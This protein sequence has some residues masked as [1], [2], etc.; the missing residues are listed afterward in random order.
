MALNYL[1]IKSD[2]KTILEQILISGD[3]EPLE[4]KNKSLCRVPVDIRAALDQAFRDFGLDLLERECDL[5][6][7][8]DYVKLSIGICRKEMAT[9]TIPVMLLADIFDT[10]T[11][12]V[13]EDMFTFVEDEVNVWKEDL[14]FTSCKNNLLRMCNDL[15]RRLSRSSATVFC[16]RIL[17]FL[18]KF[19]PFSERSGLNIVSEFNLENLTEY[20][21][22]ASEDS[23]T[24]IEVMGSKKNIVIDY[25]LYCK[26]WS[27]QDFFRNPN[28]CYTKVQWKLFCSHAT[29]IL[30]TFEG[31]KLDYVS[32][33][34]DDEDNEDTPYF[35]KYLT[36]QKLLDLQI[37]DVNFRRSVLL[38][39][40]ILFQYL[41]SNVKFKSENYEL[42]SDQKEWV[43]N[44]TEKVYALLRETPP[45]GD[46]F[47]I[48][49]KNILQREENWNVWKNDG[50]P[51]FKTSISH[52][53]ET[54][55]KC[56]KTISE[57]P[58]VGDLLK[59]AHASG[60]YYLGSTELTKLWNLSPDN[61]EACKAKDR[62]FLP[63]LD[64]Y[65][66]EAIAQLEGP[67]K[68]EDML[69]KD[70]NFGW[71]A[72]RL[73]ARRSP[74]FFAYNNNPINQLPDYLEMM[75]KKIAADRP[76]RMPE[77]SDQNV[78][79]FEESL[80]K[81]TNE[82]MKQDV[83]DFTDDHNAHS[84]PVRITPE[85]LYTISDAVASNW[86]IL[87]T[88]LGFKSDEIKYFEDNN[89][90]EVERA[91]NILQLW[92]E[93]EDDP[94]FENLAYILEGLDMVNAAEV[95]KS[96]IKSVE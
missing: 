26:F 53:D 25:S 18:A 69:L 55:D 44:V 79:E 11:L 81:E 88:K 89:S 41:T 31:L 3:I 67:A 49:I 48:I 6:I 46:K 52:V 7:L 91:Q 73:I 71:R 23:A 13:C 61:L 80:F 92:F 27:L 77:C 96:A 50:C 57:R 58:L 14:F 16:G 15:L 20:G 84:E 32:K 78:V 8:K 5:H 34:V 74:H 59:E 36:N 39:F 70:G 9:A 90:T 86:K 28:Q 83:D 72:L 94:S 19:F 38:Q 65:F 93:D 33:E 21:A 45:D 22:D 82:D 85:Q 68:V 4:Q 64:N 47:A 63:D 62:D 66:S 17:L 76:G 29:S 56:R 43:Q 2:Y 37:Y 30:S 35:S 10:L 24:E 87:A 60:R 51:E 42:K 12:E 1:T 75:V 95:V 40:L 54:S